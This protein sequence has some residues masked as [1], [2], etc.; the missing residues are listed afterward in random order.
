M[1]PDPITA[2]SPQRPLDEDEK[3]RLVGVAL[4]SILYGLRFGESLPV[5]LGTYSPRLEV[6]QACFVTLYRYEELRG[7][8]GT[9][10]ATRVLVKQVADSAF[11]AGFRDGRLPAVSSSEVRELTIEISLLSELAAIEVAYWKT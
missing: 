4:D 6:P 3:R 11:D 9:L 1:A 8:V 7:C 2:G 10:D 5:Q